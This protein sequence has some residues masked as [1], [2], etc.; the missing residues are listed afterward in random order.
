MQIGET[1]GQK[2]PNQILSDNQLVDEPSPLTG[3]ITPDKNELQGYSR[4][5]DI[6]VGIIEIVGGIAFA[7][8]LGNAKVTDTDSI[9]KFGGVQMGVNEMANRVLQAANINLKVDQ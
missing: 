9:Y 4:K 6:F 1:V 2:K 5:F 7:L 8:G 3:S